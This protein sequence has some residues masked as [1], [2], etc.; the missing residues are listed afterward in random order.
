MAVMELKNIMF[1]RH[2]PGW[3]GRCWISNM[4]SNMKLVFL[5][6]WPGPS[7]HSKLQYIPLTPNLNPQTQDH[8]AHG[9][10]SSR[11]V[12]GKLFGHTALSLCLSFLIIKWD[13]M[14]I[15]RIKWINPCKVFRP[16]PGT[17]YLLIKCQLWFIISSEK[18]LSLHHQYVC[19]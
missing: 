11:K 8:S 4:L 6:Y 12:V 13:F 2:L 7:V 10:L 15:M 19:W 1:S 14:V 16:T 18:V 9:L 17:K 3:V 5:N